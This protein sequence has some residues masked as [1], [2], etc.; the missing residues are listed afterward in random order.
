MATGTCFSAPISGAGG[1]VAGGM[2][3]DEAR[4]IIGQLAQLRMHVAVA[5]A[6]GGHEFQAIFGGHSFGGIE[7][8]LI[9]A[10]SRSA[11]P[12]A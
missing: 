3:D 8:L 11:P 7:G 6:R 10:R 9:P 2:G 5:Q 12:A 4:S 1:V